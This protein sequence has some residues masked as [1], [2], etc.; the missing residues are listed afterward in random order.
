VF[1]ISKR[2]TR[3]RHYVGSVP[4]I[5]ALDDSG[6]IWSTWSPRTHSLFKY[7][8]DRD[9][10]TFFQHGIPGSAA[11][12]GL[13]YPGAGPIDMML[14]GG[15][16]YLYVGVTTGDLVR[17]DPG[18]GDVDY[19]GKPAAETRLPAME[20][21]PDGRLWGIC[22]FLKRC[23]LFAYDRDKRSFEDFGLI[24][25]SETGTP[26]FIAHD[27]AFAP[28]GRIFVGETDTSD[29]AG[30]LWEIQL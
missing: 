17:I 21:G 9:S 5:M 14:N 16:G 3:H 29:R 18:T 11:A 13:M 1:D 7:D 27:M 8:P 20:V 2:E 19:L 6:C 24:R 15:D 12:V 4:H 28:D 30:Y 25:D 23:R 22:G 10:M 26:I